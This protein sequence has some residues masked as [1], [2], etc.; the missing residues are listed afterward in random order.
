MSKLGRYSAD[1]KKV[2]TMASSGTLTKNDCGKV[3]FVTAT[4]TITLPDAGIAGAGWWCKIVKNFGSGAGLISITATS[5]LNG[6]GVDGSGVGVNLG[7]D[8]AFHADATKGSMLEVVSD[9]TQWF[10]VGVASSA[11]GFTA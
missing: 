7:D 2:K 6:V 3:I 10:A 5:D 1:R 8:C 9:G 4:C 11:D